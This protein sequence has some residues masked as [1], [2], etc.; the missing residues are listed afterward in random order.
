MSVIT[1][2]TVSIS[3]LATALFNSSKVIDGLAAL[4][5]PIFPLTSMEVSIIGVRN[6]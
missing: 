2:T 6:E 4:A 1:T 5:D 3:P